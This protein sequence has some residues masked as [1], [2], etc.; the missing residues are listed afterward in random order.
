MII[1]YQSSINDNLTAKIL[2]ANLLEIEIKE[3][4]IIQEI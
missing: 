2:E 4:H 3:Q 1:G